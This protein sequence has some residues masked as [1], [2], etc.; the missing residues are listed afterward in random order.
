VPAS[1]PPLSVVIPTHDTREITL[2]CLRSLA[3]WLESGVEV[4][5]VDDGSRDETSVA[6]RAGFPE[7]V[8]LRSE[9]ARGFTAAANEGMAVARGGLLLLLN[10]DTEVDAPT[11]PHLY[12][13]FEADPRLGAAGASLTNLDGSPQWSGGKEPTLPWLFALTSGLGGGLGRLPGYR[14]VRPLDARAR[15]SVDWVTGAAMAVRREA[16]QAVG[17]MDTRYRFYAQDLD[18]CLSLRDAG[19]HVVLASEFH[20]M[21]LGGATIGQRSGA[22][23]SANPALLWADLLTWAEKRHGGPWARSALRWMRLGGGLRVVARAL[24]RPTTGRK[25]RS[26]WDRETAAFRSARQHL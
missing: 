13:A 17:P 18:F 23:Q 3:P 24:V 1:R 26:A 22:A 25:T 15:G 6:V 11:L 7:A 8:V 12:A 9:E 16:W 5:L 21:H 20:V 10:S 19:W 2:R 4:V 14:L